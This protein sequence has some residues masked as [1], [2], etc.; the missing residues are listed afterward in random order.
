MM[1]ENKKIFWIS[2]YPKSGNTWLRLILCGLF[3]TEDGTLN[4]FNLL[5]RIPRF[6]TLRYFKF[7]KNIS[8]KDY[9]KIF[10][11]TEFNDQSIVT[12]SKYW[13]EA[14]KRIKINK[15]N[16]AFF[17]THNARVKINNCYYTDPS[18]TLGYIYISRDPRDIVISYSKF[19]SIDFNT[20]IDLITTGQVTTKEKIDNRMPE[21]TLNWRDH[22]LSWKKFSAVPSLF[23]KYEDL[24][25]DI[26][27]EIKKITD[28]FYNNYNIKV[29]NQS[30]KIKN[31]IESTKFYNLKKIESESSFIE[32]PGSS[33]FR[34]GKRNQW[35]NILNKEQIDLL[36][37][38]FRNQLIELNYIIND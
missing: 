5:K 14:Q 31:I 17:K 22:Y 9:N 3:F 30:N 10:N 28:F 6:D 27:F 8:T 32:N 34:E 23:L 21:I 24:L 25:H 18:T 19:S 36:E 33:F 12:Y 4:D 13:I 35:I 7:I 1:F 15:G 29:E 11:S 38:K 26:E 20:A 37:Q 16:F 2:S